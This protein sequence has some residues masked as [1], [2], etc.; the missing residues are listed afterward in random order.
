MTVAD[1][2]IHKSL[3]AGLWVALGAALVEMLQAF[4]ALEFSGWW[5]GGG[6]WDQ[7]IQ[8]G[9][10]VVFVVFGVYFLWKKPSSIE[11]EAS[12]GSARTKHFF[13]G[14]LVSALNLLA[15]PY[16]IFYGTYLANDGW[17]A[18]VSL[19]SVFAFGVMAGTFVLLYFY[20]RLSL[21]IVSRAQQ[22]AW[23]TDR[24]IGVVFLFLAFVQLWRLLF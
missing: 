19:V 4:V 10:V 23:L 20:A 18:D 3:R 1:V 11:L 12:E 15:F 17:L 14:V 7:L 24:I 16:W 9:A 13:K 5:A 2:T 21:S 22:F 8:W 6:F